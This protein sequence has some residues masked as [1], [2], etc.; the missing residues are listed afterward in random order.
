MELWGTKDSDIYRAS[1]QMVIDSGFDHR[2]MDRDMLFLPL[3]S[4]TSPAV[5]QDPPEEEIEWVRKYILG[6]RKSHFS[7]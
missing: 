4:N 1:M 2:K 7:S 6:W 5:T 3:A